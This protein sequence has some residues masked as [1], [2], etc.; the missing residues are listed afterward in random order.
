MLT[1]KNKFW[2][3]LAIFFVALV[4][5]ST[6]MDVYSFFDRRQL[7]A[8]VVARQKVGLAVIRAVNRQ[9][10]FTA[11]EKQTICEQWAASQYP[12]NEQCPQ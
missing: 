6:L 9:N 7:N 5:A 8:L 4:L 10:G 3:R 11:N 12:A 2:E 1:D